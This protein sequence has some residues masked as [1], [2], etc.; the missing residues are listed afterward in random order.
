MSKPVR[1]TLYSAIYREWYPFHNLVNS[2]ETVYSPDQLED[3]NSYLVLWGGE[4]ISPSLYG[5][6]PNKHTWA[7]DSLGNRDEIEV[8]LALRAIEM[9]IPIIGICRGAQLMC[10]LSGGK[11]VQHVT[12]HSNGNHKIITKDNKE[13]S[14]SSLHHQMMYPFNV[15]HELIAKSKLN[16][17]NKYLGEEEKE[18][19]VEYEP[20]IVYFPTTKSLAIQGHPEYMDERTQ[21]VRYCQQLVEEYLNV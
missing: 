7:T 19:N 2:L 16:L 18:I 21:F 10:A 9:G 6:K 5:E 11:L 20:E 1:N 4:D 17:S 15:P 14:T 13:L 3:T 8:K 12:N